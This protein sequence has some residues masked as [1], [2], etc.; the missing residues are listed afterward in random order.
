MSHKITTRKNG[1]IRVQEMNDEPSLTH[2]SFK[3]EVDVNQIVTRH[4]DTRAPLPSPQLV[5]QD[6]SELTDYR[7]ALDNVMAVQSVFSKLPS[8]SRSYFHNDAANFLDW[9]FEH[10][11]EAVDA[12]VHGPPSPP[13]MEPSHETPDPPET[14]PEGDS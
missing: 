14:S 9:T 6:V 5:Y 10:T 12:L 7:D 8:A 13:P 11:P 1:H 2:Q 4:Q 3:D